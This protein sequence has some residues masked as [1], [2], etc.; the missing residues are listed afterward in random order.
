MPGMDISRV[1]LILGLSLILVLF[2]SPAMTWFETYDFRRDIQDNSSN[3]LILPIQ[4]SDI[5]GNGVNE[6]FYGQSGNIYFDSETDF[7]FANRLGQ[8]C[9]FQTSPQMK[10]N[11]QNLDTGL[12]SY[13]TFDNSEAWDAISVDNGSLN[14]VNT[15]VEGRI[16]DAYSFEGDDRISDTFT[17]P[18]NEDV[19]ISYW[20]KAGSQAD[21]PVLHS[22]T[23]SNAY[24]VVT[25]ISDRWGDSPSGSIS[26]GLRYDN[27]NAN[28]VY[29]DQD[30]ADNEWHHV[31]G[32][33]PDDATAGDLEIYIDGQKVSTSY[34]SGR[35]DGTGQLPGYDVNIGYNEYDNNYLAGDVDDLRIY[36]RTLSDREISDIYESAQSGPEASLGNI[37]SGVYSTDPKPRD[38][39]TIWYNDSLDQVNV[40]SVFNNIYDQG[41]YLQFYN[42]TEDLLENVSVQNGER[43][44]AT[45]AYDFKASEKYSWRVKSTSVND[46][47][48]STE[49]ELDFMTG[50]DFTGYNRYRFS[51]DH[52][53]IKSESRLLPFNKSDIDEN[54]EN[55]L[56]YGEKSRLYFNNATDFAFADKTQACGFQTIPEQINECNGS[57]ADMDFY[58]PFDNENG[59]NPLE[60]SNATIR[61]EIETGENGKIGNS[62]FFNGSGYLALDHAYSSQGIGEF[63]VASWIKIPADGGGWSIIDFDRSEYFNAVAGI[64]ESD[65]NNEGDYV[66]FHSTDSSGSTSDMWSDT[67]LRDNKWHHVAWIYN[68]T[69]KKIFIDG[70][71]DKIQ[72]IDSIGTGATRYGFIGE[73]S[74]ASSFDGERNSE[75]FEGYI[76]DLR[77]YDKGIEHT[78]VEEIF[79]KTSNVSQRPYF[80]DLKK[81]T[82]APQICD[83]TP[84]NICTSSTEHIVSGEAYDIDSDFESKSTSVLEAF[85]SPASISVNKSAKISGLWRGAFDLRAESITIRPGASFRP[86]NGDII[87]TE[88]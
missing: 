80:S 4:E 43:A 48:N 72:A 23:G 22:W 24:G 42:S 32:V 88:E 21:G 30:F 69:H 20:V 46:S 8:R 38:S 19:T 87:M 73:G 7:A 45:L 65:T 51:V 13:Y 10:S 86:E 61:G 78:R 44:T 15:G 31:V 52:S 9:G 49:L 41:G 56:F 33:K 62:Y 39:A 85:D 55:E 34:N 27:G 83:S 37:Q 6:T 59:W 14:G 25:G 79:N 84:S 5:D 11:C 12:I 77:V 82:I 2:T 60:A 17:V 40:S 18:T 16:G 75:Y 53:K 67:K 29:T 71:L 28:M 70:K 74:E 68:G 66:G 76:D 81:G 57:R 64:S 3:S 26:F 35:N 50:S 47:V 63:S 54:G 58:F 1:K 36:E